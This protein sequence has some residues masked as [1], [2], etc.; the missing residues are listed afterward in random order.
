MNIEF[1]MSWYQFDNT[2]VYQQEKPVQ[3]VF[4]VTRYLVSLLFYLLFSLCSESYPTKIIRMFTSGSFAY[5]TN[6]YY[7]IYDFLTFLLR[8][9]Y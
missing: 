7:V 3:Y 5:K 1:F 6:I 9:M 4:I 2:R 8:K